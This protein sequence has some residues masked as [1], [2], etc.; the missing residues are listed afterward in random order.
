VGVVFAGP[1]SG[2]F[3]DQPGDT[4]IHPAPAEGESGYVRN[5]TQAQEALA[6]SAP[7][8]RG[9]SR[10]RRGGASPD[11]RNEC[12]DGGRQHGGYREPE[13]DGRDQQAG[14]EYAASSWIAITSDG[15]KLKLDAFYAAGPG[16]VERAVGFDVGERRR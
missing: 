13:P 10:R 5:L 15:A 1:L 4:G 6:T 16:R 9:G 8:L 12:P 11:R 3:V 2:S 7:C 14:V